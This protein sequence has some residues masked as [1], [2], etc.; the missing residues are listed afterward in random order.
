[1]QRVRMQVAGIDGGSERI[2]RREQFALGFDA[3][4]QCWL[5]VDGAD[6]Y[7]PLRERMTAPR[8]GIARH[9]RACGCGEKKDLHVV[10]RA[11]Q[12]TRDSWKIAERGFGARVDRDRKVLVAGVGKTGTDLGQETRRQVVDAVVTDVLQKANRNR[13][14]GSGHA[15][16]QN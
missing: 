15:G 2:E 13:L 7:E 10:A 11:A 9:E 14:A 5:V 3:F 12:A 4:D 8:L 16:D 1:A 6:R